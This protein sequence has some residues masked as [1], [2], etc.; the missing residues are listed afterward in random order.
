[1]KTVLRPFTDGLKIALQLQAVIYRYNGKGGMR[2]TRDEHIGYLAQAIQAIA[3]YMVTSRKGKLTPDDTQETDL[4]DY[5][6]HA[7]VFILVNAIQEL[8]ARLV[9]L[10]TL[11]G[12]LE[13]LEARLHQLEAAAAST[14][15]AA[16]C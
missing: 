15:D 2:P 5:N 16:P 3:P 4:L 8:T 10:E 11:P 12:R 14:E 7:L 13:R 6:G 9:T 1:M